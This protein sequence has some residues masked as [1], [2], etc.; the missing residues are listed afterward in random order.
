M[1]ASRARSGLTSQTMTLEPGALG[2]HGQAPPAPAV[3]DDDEI[4]PGQKDVGGPEDAVDRALPGP[5]AVIEE[6]LG[7]GVVDGDDRILEDA[8]GRH[9]LQ[10]D[11]AG[12]RLLRAA[13]HAGE[14]GPLPGV[15]GADQ[16]GSVIHGDLRPV[17]QGG[18]EVP[19]VGLVVLALDGENGDPEVLD[20]RRGG[21]ILGAQGIR[22]GQPDIGPPEL[23]RLHQ[24]AGFARHVQAG[25]ELDPLEGFLLGERLLDR[26]RGR[27]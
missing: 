21:V 24:V 5:V 14:K 2:P 7:V 20:D 23:E 13:G 27:A 12:R 15:E 9:A 19:V 26:L 10:P 11:D 18:A 4:Q 3:A 6:V 22:G 1:T 17:V 16:V 8:L 25:R